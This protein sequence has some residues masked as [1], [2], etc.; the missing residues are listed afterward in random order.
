MGRESQLESLVQALSTAPAVVFVE[1]DVGIGKSRLVREAESLFATGSVSLLKGWCHPLREALP[2]GPVIDAMRERHGHLGPDAELTSA[3]AAALAPYLP[4]LASRLP[5]PTTETADTDQ[6]AGTSRQQLM[7][8]VH[9]FLSAIGTAVLVVEDAHWADEATRELLLLMARNPPQTLRLIVT[10]RA[11][12]LP[13]GEAVLGAPYRRP[14][15]VGGLDIR[16]L[17]LNEPQ[18]RE[19]AASAL[20]DIPAKALAHE[21]FTHSGG[22]PL[23]AEEDL[24]ALCDRIRHEGRTPRTLQGVVGVP[25]ATR[26]S[27]RARIAKLDPVAVR[28][29]QA[30][31]VLAVPTTEEQLS[32]LT[33]LDDE[34]IEAGLTAALESAI[35][36][37]TSPGWY[38]FRHELARQAVYDRIM[39][40]RRRRFHAGAVTVLETQEPPALVQIAHHTRQLGDVH[41]W[42]PRALSAAHH[43]ETLGDD[44]IAADLL[45]QLLAEPA[46]PAEQ[47]SD[48]A[49]ALSRIA[50]RRIAHEASVDLLRGIIADPA[51]PVA[52]RGEIRL[53][54]GRI[55][56]QTDAEAGKRETIRAIGEL[57]SRP[58]MAACAM[59]ALGLGLLHGPVTE[60]A[61]WM[62]RALSTIE[63]TTDPVAKATVLAHRFSF[64]EMTG[65]PLASELLE[66]LPRDSTEPEVLR[67]LARAL[68]DATMHLLWRGDD[69]RA[70][71]LLDEAEELARRTG[72]QRFEAGCA[73]IRVELDFV[74]GHWTGVDERIDNLS[75]EAAE[76]DQ[77]QLE[78]MTM[79]ALLDLAR[80]QWSQARTRLRPPLD[81]AHPHLELRMAC[82]AALSRLEMLE[83]NPQAAWQAV[84]PALESLRRKG[85]WVLTTD[86]IPAAVQAALAC[87]LREEAERLIE[88]VERGIGG[89]DAPGAV[90]ELWWCRGLLAAQADPAAGLQHLEQAC[91]RFK[92]IGRIHRAARISEQIGATL[93]A[94]QPDSPGQA[95]RRLQEATDVFTK[96]GATADEARCRQQLR[97]IGHTRPEPRGR[98][99]YGTN[100]SPRE[101]QVAQLLAGGTSN[102]DIARALS[103]S[104][105]TVEHHVART[106]KKLG[107]TREQLSVSHRS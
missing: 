90:A 10:Y 19:L 43:A 68:L 55:L 83:G 15:G 24:R 2:F 100:L 49:L 86:L 52:T 51:L 16:L 50:V 53:N 102:Q 54:L 76:N 93:L 48:A 12:D 7:R 22:W 3:S 60:D 62:N 8:A 70:C 40:P 59:A 27:I 92:A 74:H 84:Q 4:A 69:E 97:D 38:G 73:T 14:V 23:I 45:H 66:Q 103:L 81:P 29:M 64:L 58:E 106:L 21:L 104:V 25:R 94:A 18:V 39:G 63:G 20:G 36:V 41:A 61:T 80:G 35:M 46:L 98:R 56:I 85:I 99:S 82:S 5:P 78:Q 37:E 33:K 6:A 44:G 11:H 87:D 57:D 72:H 9:E 79:R 89:R 95:A 88:E 105:R 77:L 107:S 75:P 17:P 91:A 13:V 31:A 42:I 47:R 32:A 71:T 28:V 1:G 96:L 67:Q 26:E 65:D 30:A 101:E 34:Q